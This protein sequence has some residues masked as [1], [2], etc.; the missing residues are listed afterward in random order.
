[1]N[2]SVAHLDCRNLLCPLPV[3]RTQERIS[4][5]SSGDTLVVTSTDPGVTHDIPSWCRIHGHHVHEIAEQGREI[6]IT[7]HVK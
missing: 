4:T 3:I 2:D 1:M 7:I 6:I 5:L